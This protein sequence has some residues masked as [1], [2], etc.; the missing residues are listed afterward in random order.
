MTNAGEKQSALTLIELLVV[1]VIIAIV[2]AMLFPAFV[3]ARA[4]A[5]R[6]TCISG[7]RQVG[8]ALC[9]YR[10]DHGE[11]APHLSSLYP[12]YVSEPGIFVCP[13]DPAEGQHDGNDYMEGNLYLP[14]GVSY[15]YLPNWKHAL[16][17]GW[18][19]RRPKCGEGKWYA[20]TPVAMC[21]WHWARGKEWRKELDAAAWGQ[22]P[23]GW[24]LVLTAGGSVH[25]ARAEVPAAEFSPDCYR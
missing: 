7:L 16:D 25:R 18:W 1:I 2:A 24:I 20:A 5:K 13:E 22:H 14:S 3:R 6:S 17:L 21:H 11:L 23:E 4:A 8:I 15:T 9:M 10:E 19:H 12:A